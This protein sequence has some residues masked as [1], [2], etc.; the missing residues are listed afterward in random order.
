[1]SI[2]SQGTQVFALVPTAGNPSIFEVMEIE[3]ATAFSPGGNPADQIETTCLSE[4]VRSYM[5]GLRTPGQ[6]TLSLNA[7]P[8]N[9]SHVRLHQLSE[10]DSIESIR[11]VVGWSDGKGIVPTVGTS[12]ELAAISLGAGGTGYTTA[13][14]VAITGGGG[15]GATATAIVSGGAVTGFSITNAG[16]GYTSAPTIALTGG[17]GTGAAAS[18]VLGEGDDFVLP[19]TR[20]WFL[21][22]GY[23]SDFPFD[24]AANTVVTTAATIQ[25]SGGSAWIRKTV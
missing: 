15:T 17:G 2:L 13:P 10:D 1:M 23:V 3:C 22:D 24:F 12:G 14:T 18:A 25:R 11:W 5:R 9:A 16:S 19:P 7:D 6:A 8:R 20:T 4:T 21:F